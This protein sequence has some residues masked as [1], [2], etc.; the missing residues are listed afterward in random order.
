MIYVM[1]YGRLMSL[2][3]SNKRQ[4]TYFITVDQLHEETIYKKN[5]TDLT[6]FLER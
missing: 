2:R 1:F 4:I 5:V 3:S 6:H